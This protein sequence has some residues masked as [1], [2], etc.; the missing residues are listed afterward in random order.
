MQYM[1]SYRIKLAYFVKIAL[2]IFGFKQLYHTSRRLLPPSPSLPSETPL[3]YYL[4]TRL[5]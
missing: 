5:C 4:K 1:F 2:L 3:R